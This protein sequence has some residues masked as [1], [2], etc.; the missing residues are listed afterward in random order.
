MFVVKTF[1]ISQDMPG[2]LSK[3]G[4]SE[5]IEPPPDPEVPNAVAAI[6]PPPRQEI[7]DDFDVVKFAMDHVFGPDFNPEVSSKLSF[8]AYYKTK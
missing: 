2:V 3:G 1:K 8:A 5:P 6:A 4:P 7:P